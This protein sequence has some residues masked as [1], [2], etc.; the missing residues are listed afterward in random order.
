MIHRHNAA[1]TKTMLSAST[2]TIIAAIFALCSCSEPASAFTT[3]IT[4]C[5]ATS[6]RSSKP[7][8]NP[9]MSYAK[10]H[11]KKPP[12]TIRLSE[13]KKHSNEPELMNNWNGKSA[14]NEDED[15]DDDDFER[16]QQ[17]LNAMMAQQEQASMQSTLFGLE[18]KPVEDRDYQAPL[19]TGT[20]VLLFSLFFTGYGFYVFFSGDD[21]IFHNVPPTEPP[22]DSWYQK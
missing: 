10:E 18:K 1:T 16:R 4:S 7:L 22:P 19:F 14:N 8:L 5:T 2:S 13:S 9:A 20:L 12:T 17:A 3:P 21:F 6:T 11:R 15:D